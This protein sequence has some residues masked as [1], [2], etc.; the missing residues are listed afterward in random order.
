M[1]LRF[2]D[3]LFGG[4]ALGLSVWGLMTEAYFLTIFF[5]GILGSILVFKFLFSDGNRQRKSAA[6]LAGLAITL[7]TITSAFSYSVE[8]STF[9]FNGNDPIEEERIE[10]IPPYIPPKKKEKPV[11]IEKVEVFRE[12]AEIKAVE[13]EVEVIEL[14]DLIPPDDEEVIDLSSDELGDDLSMEE[15]LGMIEPEEIIIEKAKE[16]KKETDVFVIVEQMPEFIG[17]QEALLR[18]IYDNTKYP[19]M[20]KENGL[21]GRVSISFIVNEDGSISNVEVAGG[22]YE[23]L[24]REA[25]RV[26]KSMPPW[27]PGMQRG[28]PVKVKYNVPVKFKLE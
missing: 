17:G 15:L 20:A 11:P 13:K 14:E 1:R 28:K 7:G 8:E 23:I 18:Y 3:L 9:E 27:K 26:V 6:T 10:V 12:D 2:D 16:N 4:A 21:E 19:I 22:E 24:N 25:V 5:G